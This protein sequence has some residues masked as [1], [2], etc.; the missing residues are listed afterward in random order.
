[1]SQFVANT[2]VCHNT[3]FVRESERVYPMI[4]AEYHRAPRRSTR[5]AWSTPPGDIRAALIA[6]I[7]SVSFGPRYR[8]MIIVG[9][10]VGYRL[11]SLSGPSHRGRAQS[12]GDCAGCD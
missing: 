2:Q 8:C 3:T 5:L 11:A 4:V 9:L 12:R 6:E 1:M 7:A 10:H